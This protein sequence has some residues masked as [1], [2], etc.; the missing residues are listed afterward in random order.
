MKFESSEELCEYLDEIG[1]PTLTFSGFDKAII[2]QADHGNESVMVYDFDRIIKVMMDRDGVSR[3]D[4]ELWYV[5]NMIST[6]PRAPV[7]LDLK[8]FIPCSTCS[9]A[10][11]LRE[12]ER[13]YPD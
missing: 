1:L 9:L 6:D 5:R 3:E 8:V 4:A 7:V 11:D 10:A 12:A 2:G 13:G